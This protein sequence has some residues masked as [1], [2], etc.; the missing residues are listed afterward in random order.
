L[1]PPKKRLHCDLGGGPLEFGVTHHQFSDDRAGFGGTGVSAKEIVGTTMLL[2]GMIN[3]IGVLPFYVGLLAHSA[4]RYS[5]SST[6]EWMTFESLAD[7]SL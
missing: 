5:A 4:A 2:Y 7:Y 6:W 3:P 1:A